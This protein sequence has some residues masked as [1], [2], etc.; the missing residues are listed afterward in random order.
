MNQICEV[1]AKDSGAEVFWSC[2]GGCNRKFHASCVGVSCPPE[3]VAK[4]RSSLRIV[5]KDKQ[6]K[7][8]KPAVD[9]TA[10]LLP[11]CDS[12]QLLVT[13]SFELNTLT[14]QQNKLT[15]LIDDNTEVIHRL[16]TQL[17]QPSTIPETL[18]GID[19]SLIQINQ[20]LT[21]NIKANSV[22]GVMP[23]LKNHLTQLVNIAFS[24]FKNELRNELTESLTSI[25]NELS[26][27]G[28]LFVETA[29]SCSIQTNPFEINIVDELKTLSSCIEE[30]RSQ[31][32]SVAAPPIASPVSLPSLATEL[33][34]DNANNS[35]W[36]FLG[37]KKVWKADWTD[38]DER[39]RRRLVQLKNADAAR[40]RRNRRQQAYNNNTNNNN[41]NGNNY[42][43]RNNNN[44]LNNNDN[45]NRNNNIYNHRSNNN[46]QNRNNNNYNHNNNIYNN[47][48]NNNHQNRNNNNFNRNNNIYNN[49][50]I[51][52]SNNNNNSINNNNNQIP[53]RYLNLNRNL[54]NSY[55]NQ[56]PPD[57][58]L[59]AAA[60]DKF[61]RPPPNLQ[62]ISFQRGEILNPYPAN[63]ESQ[64]SFMPTVSTSPLNLTTPATS[65]AVSCPYHLAG[66]HNYNNNNNFRSASFPCDGCYCKHSCSQ[67]Q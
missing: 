35:G 57:R 6:D 67:N 27:L 31:S 34:L 54:N 43:N 63:N 26:Q 15:K 24:E 41:R 32:A 59:L 49:R 58:V 52:N 42:N 8:D 38:Y 2:V 40:R 64:S 36:R 14:K 50:N 56:L 61:S 53:N 25:N 5:K 20:A 19:K 4:S 1:C 3:V 46:H 12:C 13:A 47:R 10:F 51:N 55:Y 30:L 18:E 29:T 65:S 9:P 62:H 28:Q 44:H 48:S 23:T 37:S 17:E 60:K 11:C 45:Y 22:A 39:K 66:S 16:V 7:Q 33:N 21:S